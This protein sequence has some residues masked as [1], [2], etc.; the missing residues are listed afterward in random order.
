M[1]TVK[2]LDRRVTIAIKTFERPQCLTRLVR[3]IRTRYD[4][5]GRIIVADDSRKPVV[6]QDVE[7]H[8]LP[9]DSG[10]SAGR[11]FLLSRAPTPYFLLLDDDHVFLASTTL[12]RLVHV[13][14]TTDIDIVGMACTDRPHNAGLLS[15]RK[16]VLTHSAGSHGME[17][18]CRVC[19]MVPNTFLARTQAVRALGGWDAGLKLGEHLEFFLRAKGKLK[20]ASCPD[21]KIGHSRRAPGAYGRFRSRAIRYLRRFMDAYGITKIV[22]F[23]RTVLE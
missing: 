18:G 15:L 14:D 4:V 9:F 1:D 3:S 2:P 6:L 13:L 12:E 16:G 5:S 7:Y 10:V 21:V 20:V 8:C 23:G 19:D 17:A 11:N 22:R